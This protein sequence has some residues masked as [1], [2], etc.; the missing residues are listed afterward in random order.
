M[1]PAWRPMQACAGHKPGA[2]I[3]PSGCVVNKETERQNQSVFFP[4]FACGLPP[5]VVA[6]SFPL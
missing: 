4:R 3:M 2:S 5:K 1:V 6:I